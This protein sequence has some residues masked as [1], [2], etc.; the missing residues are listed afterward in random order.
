MGTEP[1]HSTSSTWPAFEALVERNNG[2]FGGCWCIGFHP[3]GVAWGQADVNRQRKH[4]RVLAGT[5][6]AALVFEG[7]DCVGWC[8]FGSP[9]EVPRIKSRAAY[10]KGLIALP[11]WRIVC[12]F[13]GKGHRRKGVF[14]AALAG[15]LDLIARPWRRKRRGLSRRCRF[16]TRGLSLP[17]RAV[18]IRTARLRAR[19]Q[20][21]QAPLGRFQARGSLVELH[22]QPITQPE[23]RDEF[24]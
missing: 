22:V 20:D 8:Q 4:D 11:D 1:R 3:E 7:A 5:T 2:V 15:A 17:W 12:C 24:F 19:P 6:H 14:A 13:V 18:D 10:E 16:G 9:D 21:W 23:G